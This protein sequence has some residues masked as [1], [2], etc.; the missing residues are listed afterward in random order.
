MPQSH[1]TL[2]KFPQ[3]QINIKS[4]SRFSFH[5]GNKFLQNIKKNK[6]TSP[7]YIHH[8]QNHYTLQH[9]VHWSIP[10]R[11]N[12]IYCM[13]LFQTCIAMLYSQFTQRVINILRAKKGKQIRKSSDENKKFYVVIKFR[14]LLSFYPS[15]SLQCCIQELNS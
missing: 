14:S 13:Y 15:I 5:Q 7:T 12:N 11:N 1:Y 9:I 2:C 8:H 10:V 6:I 4:N 3:S